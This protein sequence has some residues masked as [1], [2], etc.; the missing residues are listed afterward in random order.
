MSCQALYEIVALI[1]DIFT[2]LAAIVA[3][4]VA[5]AGVN[6]WRK[7]LTGKTEYEVARRLLR[8]T[9]ALR[10][11]I[12]SVRSPFMS[13]GEIA[14]AM[15]RVGIEPEPGQVQTPL[16]VRRAAYE[17][18]WK[19][20]TD[21][22]STLSAEAFEAEVLWGEGVTS[23]LTPLR[24]AVN[25]LHANLLIHLD[26]DSF[27]PRIPQVPDDRPTIEAVVFGHYDLSD[28][29]GTKV[30]DAVAKVENFVRPHM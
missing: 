27:A 19:E 23:A 28:E 16:P 13:G 9:Y 24:G 26:T 30:L 11:A 3:G 18:R 20:V 25:V 7:Q 4:Y 8:A 5:V 21:A 1:K 14:S 2:I 12:R 6:T 29:F 10:D 17:E 15:E 22:L